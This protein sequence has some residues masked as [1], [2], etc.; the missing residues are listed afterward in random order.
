MSKWTHAICE[1][2]WAA[3]FGGK[4]HALL[5]P[6]V[7][8]CCFCAEMTDAGIYVRHAPDSLLCKGVH[9]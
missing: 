1:K 6:D 2:C 5:Q 3:Q 9:D 4:P 7:E 8:A